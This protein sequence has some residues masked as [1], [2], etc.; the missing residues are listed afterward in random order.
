ME[1]VTERISLVCIWATSSSRANE[2]LVYD[3]SIRLL[4]QQ[5][6]P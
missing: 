2:A 3:L 1:V 5:N 4:P 6:V